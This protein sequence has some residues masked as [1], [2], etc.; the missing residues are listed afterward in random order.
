[1]KQSVITEY[2]HGEFFTTAQIAKLT[3]RAE[4]SFDWYQSRGII[5]HATCRFKSPR[6]ILLYSRN[7]VR[8][9][10]RAFQ[11]MDVEEMRRTEMRELLDRNWT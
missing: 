2:E 8:A 4:G 9:L 6:G 11:A 3:K 7:Q 10:V 1:L 5:P